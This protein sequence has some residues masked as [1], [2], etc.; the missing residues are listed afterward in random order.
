M[1]RLEMRT[2]AAMQQCLGHGALTCNFLPIVVDAGIR[3]GCLH[4]CIS[5]SRQLAP[6]CTIAGIQATRANPQV[7]TS[8]RMHAAIMDTD[9]A[10][11]NCALFLRLRA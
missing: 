3:P 4:L 2:G 11:R 8:N 9:T 6:H 7:A 10:L 5:A 1:I